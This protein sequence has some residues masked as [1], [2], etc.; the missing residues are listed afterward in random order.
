MKIIK[1]IY[2]ENT[3]WLGECVDGEVVSVSTWLPDTDVQFAVKQWM[4]VKNIFKLRNGNKYYP[5]GHK[6]GGYDVYDGTVVL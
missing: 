3:S 1:K 2:K 4:S 6:L 5:L